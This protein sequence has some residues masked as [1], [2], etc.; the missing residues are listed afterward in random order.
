MCQMH[1]LT[2]F[3]NLK[4]INHTQFQESIWSIM[5]RQKNIFE[6]LGHKLA[7]APKAKDTLPNLTSKLD[8]CTMHHFAIISWVWPFNRGYNLATILGHL[9]LEFRYGLHVVAWKQWQKKQVTPWCGERSHVHHGKVHGLP[10]VLKTKAIHPQGEV[11]RHCTNVCKWRTAGG[12][13]PHTYS[14][15]GAF[16]QIM[17][18]HE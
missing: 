10:F 2:T 1:L 15:L 16:F 4:Q 11:Q 13:P 17:W 12:V 6:R 5:Q 8:L 18:F 14:L 9:H 3:W 7:K